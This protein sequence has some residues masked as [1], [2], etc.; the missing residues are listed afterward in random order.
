MAR[1][2]GSVT[3]QLKNLSPGDYRLAVYQIGSGRNDPYSRYL[4]MGQPSDLNREAI[5]G[6]KK[7]SGGIPVSKTAVTIK[8]D[9]L[10][11]ATLPLREND[12]YFLSLTAGREH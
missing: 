10:L 5:A 8:A 11:E 3:V 6:L 7:L 12:V 4:E 1:E 2:K 9:G